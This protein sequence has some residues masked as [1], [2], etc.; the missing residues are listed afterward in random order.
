MGQDVRSEKKKKYVSREKCGVRGFEP[1]KK[2]WYVR[3]ISLS[4]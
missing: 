1:I 4:S 3:N 2:Y